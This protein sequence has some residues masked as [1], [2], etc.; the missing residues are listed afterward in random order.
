[1][2]LIPTAT[3]TQNPSMT[4][5]VIFL[6][7]MAGGEYTSYDLFDFLFLS[8]SFLLFVILVGVELSKLVRF[9]VSFEITMPLDVLLRFKSSGLLAYL[10]R[11]LSIKFECCTVSFRFCGR[12][13]LEHKF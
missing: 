11:S 10:V 12:S 5:M 9:I 7:D 6:R 8:P 4:Q 1:M 13:D 2:K 3:A